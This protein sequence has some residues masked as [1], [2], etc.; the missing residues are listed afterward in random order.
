[1]EEKAFLVNLQ[2]C[3][4][5][6]ACQV[7]CKTWHKLPPEFPVFFEGPSLQNPGK[8]SASTWSLVIFNEVLR[9]DGPYWFFRKHQ[10]MHCHSALCMKACKRQAIVRDDATGLVWVDREICQGNQDCR[11]ACPYEAILFDPN[12]KKAVKCD[13]CF[14]RVA[15]GMLPSCAASCSS[16]AI[17]FGPRPEMLKQAREYLRKFPEIKIYGER[18]PY[19]GLGVLY[20]YQGNPD[21]Y[22]FKVKSKT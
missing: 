10:C 18:K 19:D 13:F 3:V 22:R 21:R 8:L 4:G 7:A 1:M 6:R 11:K 12:I 9:E 16:E 15:Q 14:D 2:R 20:L 5:C 17:S